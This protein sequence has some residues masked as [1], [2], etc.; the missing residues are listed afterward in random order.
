MVNNT[1][2]EQ[3]KLLNLINH[4]TKSNFLINTIYEDL[5][6]DRLETNWQIDKSKRKQLI[7]GFFAYEFFIIENALTAIKD[8]ELSTSVKKYLIDCTKD[9]SIVNREGYE[10]SFADNDYDVF[11]DYIIYLRKRADAMFD[12]NKSQNDIQQYCGFFLLNEILNLELSNEDKS[13]IFSLC[14]QYFDKIY[15]TLYV[16]A[17]NLKVQK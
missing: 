8:N 15:P 2:L 4:I 5:L 11:L 17:F 6:I 14:S 1:T 3:S 10:I 7:L 12:S 16:E 13:F 9:L